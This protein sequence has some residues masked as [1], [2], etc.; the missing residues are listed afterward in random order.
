M[1]PEFGIP[2]SLTPLESGT[3]K[4]LG[5]LIIGNSQIHLFD[6]RKPSKKDLKRPSDEMD[7]E[8]EFESKRGA[9]KRRKSR[10]VVDWPWGEISA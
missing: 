3:G 9:A 7:E 8:N 5:V 1:S 2:P 4:T 6:V 10:S